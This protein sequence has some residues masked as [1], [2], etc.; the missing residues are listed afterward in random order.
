[1]R[2]FFLIFFIKAYVVGTHLN[3]IDK[4]MQFKWEPTT[5]VFIKKVNKKYTGCNK[6]TEFHE[7]ALIGDCTVI[8]SNTV[9]KIF[10]NHFMIVTMM[11]LSVQKGLVSGD[12]VDADQAAPTGPVWSESTQF[13]ITSVF[14]DALLSWGD[15]FD[16]MLVWLQQVFRVSEFL[17]ILWYWLRMMCHLR[18][19]YI[20]VSL[21]FTCPL[22]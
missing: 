17:G 1:M 2:L 15:C 18:T 9:Y 22:L 11:V 3:C 4:S 10:S 5:Y 20:I 12:G 21:C 7:C 19:I 16:R 6:T 8:R 14:L 13:A